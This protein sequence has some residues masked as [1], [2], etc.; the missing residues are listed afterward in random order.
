MTQEQQQSEEESVVTQPPD[1]KE[2]LVAIFRPSRAG[3]LIHYAVGFVAFISG[4]L[5]NVMSAGSIIPYSTISWNMG[6]GA[7]VFGLVIVLGVE[8]ARRYTLYVVTTWNV[9][10]R[11]GIISKHTRRVFYDDISK[12]EIAS[13]PQEIAVGIG[14]VVI[15]RESDAEEPVLVMKDINNPRGIR[16]LIMRFV[17]TTEEPT[18]WSH[19]EKTVVAPW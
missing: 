3:R 18:S 16:E 11:T 6:V 9:R 4:T 14:D 7:I 19:I 2:K 15:Y 1:E 12:V 17:K 8:A 5:F 13:E 10:I